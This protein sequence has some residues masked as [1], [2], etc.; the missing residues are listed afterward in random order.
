MLAIVLMPVYTIMYRKPNKGIQMSD[1]ITIIA[2]R[3][4]GVDTCRGCVMSTHSS[5]FRMRV[6]EE[7]KEAADFQ[8]TFLVDNAHNDTG[9]LCVWDLIVMVNG[10]P[11]HCNDYCSGLELTEPEEGLINLFNGYVVQAVQKLEHGRA[12]KNEQA[13]KAAERE[14]ARAESAAKKKR[15]E[16]LQDL[17]KEF[18]V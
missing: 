18:E 2:Y 9:G 12:V 11:A 8:A 10:K 16:M 5:D 15:Y 7:V 17:K 1:V 14:K 3:A 4:D 6:F 13:A